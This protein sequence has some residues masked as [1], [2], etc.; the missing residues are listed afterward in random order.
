MTQTGIYIHIPFCKQKCKY[1][2]FTSFT[3]LESMWKE[4]V[5]CILKEIENKAVQNR[6]EF[7]NKIEDLIEVDTI[8]FGGG[9]P[10]ILPEEY[11]EKILNKI[12]QCFNVSGKAE[13]T[14]EVNPRYRKFSKIRK[15]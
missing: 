7:K 14:L 12:R 5:E 10:S 4:Y 11:I 3:N 6:E 13:I 9:T 2:D 1:C 15:L 8:Y